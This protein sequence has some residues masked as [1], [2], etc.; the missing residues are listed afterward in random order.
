[1]T[2]RG[3]LVASS[4][5]GN[6]GSPVTMAEVGGF[7]ALDLVKNCK[8]LGVRSRIRIRVGSGSRL[9]TLE[10]RTRRSKVCSLKSFHEA[11]IDER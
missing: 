8:S 10:K 6:H 3:H 11:I 4:T 5:R 9:Q 1:M 2:G 7:G